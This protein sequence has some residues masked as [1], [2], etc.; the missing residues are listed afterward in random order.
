LFAGYTEPEGGLKGRSVV[1][2][3]PENNQRL[4]TGDAR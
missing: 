4:F 3:A 1:K 2:T